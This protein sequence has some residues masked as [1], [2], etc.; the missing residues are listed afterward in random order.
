MDQIAA[1]GWVRENIARFG[2][3]PANITVF[4]Q[5]AGAQNTG[6]L[7]ASPLAKDQFQRAIAESGSILLSSTSDAGGAE[8]SGRSWTLLLNA[9]ESGA[10][11]YLRG[12]TAAELVK[13]TPSPDR[14]NRR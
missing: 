5:S 3:D 7:M 6:L 14:A 12:K 9:P 11:R 4:G 1:L 2:G 8:K 10:I 13:L